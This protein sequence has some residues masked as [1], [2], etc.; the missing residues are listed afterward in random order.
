[1]TYLVFAF[2]HGGGEPALKL[3]LFLVLPMFCIWFSDAMGRYEG[4]SLQMISI[5]S[6][7]AALV[8]VLGWLLLLLPVIMAFVAYVAA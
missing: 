3:C 6:S 4:L 5:S 8:R 7:P 1:M 2:A